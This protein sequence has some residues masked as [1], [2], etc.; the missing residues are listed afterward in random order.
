MF[1]LEEK[2]EASQVISVPTKMTVKLTDPHYSVANKYK[3]TTCCN[4]ILIMIMMKI[5]MT[6]EV[7]I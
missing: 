5:L 1:M 3:I 2:S 4:L 7:K 6:I